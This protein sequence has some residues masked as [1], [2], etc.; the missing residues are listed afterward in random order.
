M[1][2]ENYLDTLRRASFDT[3]NGVSLIENDDVK[4][5]LLDEMAKELAKEY[6]MEIP[7]TC[8]SLYMNESGIYIIEF[9]N[10]EYAGITSKDKREIRKKAYQTPELL[11]NSI[12]RDR[13][14]EDIARDT[15]LFV[16]FKNM[17]EKEESYGK[18]VSQ[19]NSL[20]NGCTSKIRCKL[21]RFKGAFYK[22]VHTV[23]K[24]EFETVYLPRICGNIEHSE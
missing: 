15:S 16:V 11:A 22:D 19:M 18:F 21:G 3:A 1:D 17:E 5:Y 24:E 7:S 13:T 9:K 12:F 20:A 10:R 8:D 23:G 2:K 6:E 4:V 14:M